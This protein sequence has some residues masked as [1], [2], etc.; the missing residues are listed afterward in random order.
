MNRNMHS[1]F[2][3][4]INF[5]I[6][7]HKEIKIHFLIETSWLALVTPFHT[8]TERYQ[9]RFWTLPTSKEGAV[10]VFSV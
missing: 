3:I 1:S 6:W 4:A 10:Y 5:E 7:V 2:F 8:T 9:L